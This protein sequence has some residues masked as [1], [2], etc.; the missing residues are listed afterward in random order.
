MIRMSSPYD[1]IGVFFLFS[2]QPWWESPS[3][4]AQRQA[5]AYIYVLFGVVSFLSKIVI[6]FD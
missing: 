3:R 5:N 1:L 2:I 6:Y 4:K